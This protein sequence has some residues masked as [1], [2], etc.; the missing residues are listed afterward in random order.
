MQIALEFHQQNQ[1]GKAE[2]IYRQVLLHEPANPDALHL[3]GLIALDA[4]NND[5]SIDL[6]RRAIALRPR[7]PEALYNLGNSLR[8]SGEFDRAAEAFSASVALRPNWAEALCNLG[9]VLKDQ[10]KFNEAIACFEKAI[11]AAPGL[12]DAHNNLGAALKETKRFEQAA[13]ASRRAIELRPDFA[14]AH[15]NLGAA[16]D[17]LGHLPEAITCFRRAIELKPNYIEAHNNLGAALHRAAEFEEAAFAYQRAIQLSPDF[18][19]AHYNL[20]LLLLLRG[21]Y[22]NGWQEYEW[23]LRKPRTGGNLWN[24]TQPQWTGQ[25]IPGQT[26]FL[27]DEQGLGDALHFVRYATLA[28]QRCGKV[29]LGCAP[30]LARLLSTLPGVDE[31]VV[32]NQSLPRFDAHCRLMSLPAMLGPDPSRLTSLVPYLKANA[33]EVET[34]RNR[35]VVDGDGF[36]VGLV[37]A[38]NPNHSHDRRRSMAL[39]DFAPLAKVHG[40]QF[41]S[42]QKEDAGMQA[43][44]PPPGLNLIDRT[45]LLNDFAD[46]A[47]LIM[48]LNLVIA[49]D[50]STAHLAGAL[51]Q[52]V[53]TLHASTPD[54]RWQLGR[55]DSPWYPSMRL[56]RQSSAGDWKT[57]MLEVRKAL[58]QNALL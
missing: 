58:E 49:V 6:I 20:A 47:A 24:L 51:G 19:E 7:W 36:R 29:I 33:Q 11:A 52:P 45:E 27:H 25:P 4:G 54:W 57:V 23:R 17:E 13:A 5:Q 28:A 39:S 41:Y 55:D 40:V 48:N 21:N 15:S 37:W 2:A 14:Q 8:A 16:L 12:P 18:A 10:G 43:D 22:H 34:W 50:T 9:S 56:F 38:G 26:L 44:N 32:W 42:L 3:L 46:T 1:P 35:L 30:P 53:W 31:C